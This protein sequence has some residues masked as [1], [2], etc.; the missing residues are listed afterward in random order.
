MEERVAEE[1]TMEL[2]FVPREIFNLQRKNDKDELGHKID[3]LD[4]KLETRT[5]ELN[6]R[7]DT[8][9]AKVDGL[10]KSLNAKIDRVETVLTEKIDRVETVLSVAVNSTN[11]RLDSIEKTLE[12]SDRKRTLLVSLFGLLLTALVFLAPIVA[13]VIAPAIQKFFLIN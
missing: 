9:N 3:L 8:L 13:P 12:K 2:Q 1:R 6:G 4:A 7:I 5:A 10:D 11:N